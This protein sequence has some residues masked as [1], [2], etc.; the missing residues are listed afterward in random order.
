MGAAWT[1]PFQSMILVA[2]V[3]TFVDSNYV[4]TDCAVH[5]SYYQELTFFLLVPVITFVAVGLV[6][7]AI[8]WW[9]ALIVPCF[10]SDDD[11]SPGNLIG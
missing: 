7:I 4:A 3:T 2:G 8:Y 11:S 1:D 9:Q 5:F 6:L 10:S